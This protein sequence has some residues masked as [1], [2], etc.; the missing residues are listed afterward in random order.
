MESPARILIVEDDESVRLSLSLLLET[1]GL[2]VVAVGSGTE[3]MGEMNRRFDIFVIDM[4]LPDM[5][6]ATLA[7]RLRRISP[8]T[9]AIIM[10]AEHDRLRTAA[11]VAIC[12]L[13][14][15]VNAQAMTRAIRAAAPHMMMM[16][17]AGAPVADGWRPPA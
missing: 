15:P 9:P 17:T 5:D 16:P 10:S 13:D 3:A 8:A 12:L 4:G 11:P 2:T 6:G 1:F 7:L 14:K